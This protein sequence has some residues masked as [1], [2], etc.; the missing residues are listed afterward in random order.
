MFDVLSVTLPIFLIVIFGYVSTRSNVV[1]KSDVK[2]LGAFVIKFALPALVF[3]SLSQRSFSEIANPDFLIVYAAASLSTFFVVFAAARLVGGKSTTVSALQALGSSV[4]NSGFIGYPIAF[5][6]LGSPVVVAL[7]LAMMVENILMIPLGLILAEIGS[8][9]GKTLGALIRGVVARLVKNPLIIAILAGMAISLSGFKLPTA[10]FRAVD[11]MA[12]A[13]GALALFYVGG[14]LVGL[15]V[16]GMFAD[17]GRVVVGKLCLHPAI[18]FLALLLVP[19]LDPNLRK[20]MLIFASVPVITIFPLLGLPYRQED[21]CAAAL[22]VA[23]ILSFFTIS[24]L[25]LVL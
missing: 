11:M 6:V 13:S 22:M 14:T 9:D 17:V 8:N 20:A 2:V 21:M 5:L 19:G 23:T 10:L 1:V 7:A 18:V 16:K 24:T 12:Q 4:S 25:L 15:R 3:R